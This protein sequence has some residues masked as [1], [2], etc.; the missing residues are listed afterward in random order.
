MQDSLQ[1]PLQSLVLDV[2]GLDGVIPEALVHAYFW[3]AFYAPNN[4]VEQSLQRALGGPSSLSAVI[5]SS[6]PAYLGSNG[7][8]AP[9]RLAHTLATVT[10]I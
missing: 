8:T 4:A 9:G 2:V 10:P 3:L 6:A 1:G 7:K 5:L